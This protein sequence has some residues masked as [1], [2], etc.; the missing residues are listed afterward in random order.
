MLGISKD[1]GDR[2]LTDFLIDITK[3]N[4]TKECAE[5][6]YKIMEDFND[7]QLIVSIIINDSINHSGQ[8]P[9]EISN[10]ES[11][12]LSALATVYS[13]S[14]KADVPPQF[15]DLFLGTDDEVIQKVMR[16][17]KIQFA[18][19]NFTSSFFHFSHFETQYPE[20]SKML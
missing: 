7:S 12:I 15:K 2:I 4:G 8:K 9:Q 6:S 5:E 18:V 10:F 11:A 3:K 14:D 13:T 16:N 1:D 20:I 19:Q 17:R